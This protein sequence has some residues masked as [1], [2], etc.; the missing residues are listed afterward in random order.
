MNGRK[1]ASR[2]LIGLAAAV[3]AT[4]MASVAAASIHLYSYDPADEATRQ[5]SGALTFTFDKGLFHLT[6]L[7]VRSTEAQATAYLHRADER[8]LGA[9]GLVRVAGS[10]P[11]AR[12]LYEVEPAAEGAAL[13]GALCPG[14]GRAW[15]AFGPVHLDQDLTVLVIGAPAGKPAKLCR[16]L[17]FTFHGEWLS[18]PGRPIDPRD[19]ERARYPGSG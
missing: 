2:P 6:M 5:A 9:G 12:D 18:P 4:V 19:L 10:P 7:N 14:A 17:R 13:I 3:W 16:T 1:I 15:M 11:A 8:A